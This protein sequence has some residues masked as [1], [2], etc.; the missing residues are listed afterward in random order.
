MAVLTWATENVL[1][2]LVGCWWGQGIA[3]AF[4]RCM[5]KKILIH[6]NYIL[7]LKSSFTRFLGMTLKHLVVMLQSWSLPLLPGS[8]W[9]EMVFTV[10]VQS[11]GQI[12]LFNHLPKI[13]I[14]SEFFRTSVSWWFFTG[15]WVTA[16]LHKSVC[17]LFIFARN[18]WKNTIINVSLQYLKPFN[19]VQTKEL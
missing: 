11:M 9:L 7:I 5:M 12:E 14:L 10:R 3:C 2:P 17:E 16:S 4:T 15:V 18:T 1:S 6:M 13:I 19:C 8:L